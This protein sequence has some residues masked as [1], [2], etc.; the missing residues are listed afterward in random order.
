MTGLAIVAIT[1]LVCLLV[2]ATF[3]IL[4]GIWMMTTYIHSPEYK[5]LKKEME[6]YDQVML[7]AAQR[8]KHPE[9]HP[10]TL[11]DI[12]KQKLDYSEVEDI[13]TNDNEGDE[14]R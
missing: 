11:K 13:F 12:S 4:F 10:N 14:K 3:F 1:L 6:E 2:I 9:Y 8:K 5:K 7:Y